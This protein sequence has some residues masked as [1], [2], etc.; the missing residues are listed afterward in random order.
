MADITARNAAIL[1]NEKAGYDLQMH[2][3]GFYLM[4]NIDDYEPGEAPK[5]FYEIID[6]AG[7]VHNVNGFSY[8][9][10]GATDFIREVRL[11][12]AKVSPITDLDQDQV[13]F[14]GRMD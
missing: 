1:K 5:N 11:V 10:M 8:S 14:L 9:R 7:H 13:K 3:N 2:Y 6:P 4:L 12:M